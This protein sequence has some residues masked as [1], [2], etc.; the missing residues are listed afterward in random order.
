MNCH[1]CGAPMELFDRRRYYYCRHCG[2]FHFIQTEALDGVRVLERRDAARACPLCDV[3]LAHAQLDDMLVVE[4]CERCRGILMARATFG[5]AV[6]LRRARATGAGVPPVPLDPRELQR[7][8]KCPSCRTPMDVHPYHGPGNIVID[9]C[10]R[11]D[12]IWLDHGEL[13]QIAEAPGADRGVRASVLQT[14]RVP[15]ESLPPIHHRRM[16]LLDLLDQLLG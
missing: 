13:K 5:Q 4:H 11:C 3:P 15:D 12:L 8:L 7:R 14:R 1:N 9:N 10:S 2:T 6:T 16:S